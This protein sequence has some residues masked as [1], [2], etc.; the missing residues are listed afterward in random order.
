MSAVR[1]MSRMC[2]DDDEVARIASLADETELDGHF[3]E[4][5]GCRRALEADR[6]TRAALRTQPSPSL[7]SARRRAIA[8]ELFA[9][10]DATAQ[11]SR[12]L[13][14]LKLASLAVGVVAAAAALLLVSNVQSHSEST[15]T[16]VI[17]D[18]TDREPAM[19][20]QRI[21]I[22]DRAPALS[23]PKISTRG[24]ATLSH[25]VGDAL[26]VLV[27]VDGLIDVDTR[28]SRNVDVRVGNST[29]H[30]EDASVRI[31]ARKRSIMSVHVVVGAARITAPDQQIVLER[32][33]VW[34][35]DSPQVDD[36]ISAFRDAWI[37]LR[38]GHNRAAMD[39]FSRVTDKVVLEEAMYWAAIAA[40]RTGDT[41]LS[42]ARMRAFHE[43]FP[44]SELGR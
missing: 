39:L 12:T 30:I 29:I 4:C 2:F 43:Q 26:D 9:R 42:E 22:E 37:E 15:P 6:R 16:V 5:L 25:H 10:M 3:T 7:P 13:S 14:R 18:N 21:A 44:D 38:A 19:E 32:D 31:R 41:A 35:P 36:S 24:G 23:P 33:S 17:G 20:F 11:P 34:M 8:A 27:L 1:I 40:Q 28:T